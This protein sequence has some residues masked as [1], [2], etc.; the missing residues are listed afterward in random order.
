MG[1]NDPIDDD[2]LR[3]SFRLERARPHACRATRAAA[4]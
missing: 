2:H 3:P 4:G 1:R